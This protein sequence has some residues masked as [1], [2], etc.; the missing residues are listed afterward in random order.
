MI[1]EAGAFFKVQQH[2]DINQHVVYVRVIKFRP[3]VLE[4]NQKVDTQILH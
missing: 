2:S 3:Q 1:A 4:N